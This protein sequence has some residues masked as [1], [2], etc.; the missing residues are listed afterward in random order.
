MRAERSWPSGFLLALVQRR[1][2]RLDLREHEDK[3]LV[4]LALVISALVGLVVVG[5]VAMTERMGRILLTAGPLQRLVSPVIGS[6]A[7][8]WLLYRFFPDARG[9]GIPQTRIALILQKGVIS[10]RTVVGKFICSAVSLGSGLALGREGPSVHIG[11]G[12]ASVAGRRLGLS[13]EKLRTLIPVGTAAAIAA[14]FNTPLAA[15]LF[16]LEEI[17]ADLHARLV[18]SVVLGAATSWIVLRLILGDEPL[19]HVPAY[20]LVHPLEFVI[21]GLL[22]IIGGLIS[23]GFVK[24]LLWQRAHF[25]RV[26]G[27]WKA[28]A[29]VAGGLTVGLLA[30]V[31]PGVL[32]VGYNLVS[33]ALN[34]HVEIRVMLILMV[35]KIVATSTSYG[36]GNCGGVFGP[37]LFIGA[38]MGGAI[39]QTAHSLFPD[40][41]GNAGAYA[42]VG[43]GAAFAGIVRTP[44]TSVIMIFEVTRDY[45][46]IVPLM[47]ANLLSYLLAERLQTLPLYEALSRQEGVR[48]PSAEH[49][50]EPMAVERAMTALAAGDTLTLHEVFVHPDDPLDAALQRMG[51]AN[52]ENIVVLNRTG[53]LP[54]GAL[55][56]QSAFAAYR[57]PAAKDN[58]TLTAAAQDWLPAIAAI[59][60]ASV[61]IVA[62]LVFWQRAHRS[63]TGASE[64]RTGQ[65]LLGQGRVE[66]AV[67]AFRSSLAHLPA[68]SNARTAL[69]FALLRSG[70][71]EEAGE[72]LAEAAK[73]QPQNGLLWAGV[74]NV[75]LALDQ[76]AEALQYFR[77]ALAGEWPDSETARLRTSQIT[78]SQLLAESGKR[79]EAVASLFSV[80]EQSGGDASTGKQAA[81][82]IKDIG[83]LE[84]SE[85]AYKALSAHFPADPAVWLALGDVR[86]AANK[87]RA[88]LEAYRN[89]ATVD[90]RNEAAARSVRRV[91][92]VMDI[93]P[94]RRGLGWEERSRRWDLLFERVLTT[95]TPCLG[96]GELTA[97]AA[98]IQRPERSLKTQHEKASA[99]QHIWATVDAACRTDAVLS[100]VIAN[101][102]E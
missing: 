96:S 64:Y 60:L 56:I 100:H 101:I 14:A 49:I 13:D 102:N 37:S 80:M 48:M 98:L 65:E 77:R 11:A 18:G 63:A 99:I 88:A 3:I 43:M 46:I 66:E 40:Y 9:S 31:H 68:D 86:F 33:E 26:P 52:V 71:F 15:V 75:K 78:F 54:V 38:M 36:S 73:A 30:L 29:P 21:Y 72:Y 4:M 20:Q 39:G 90:P 93:D 47:I 70:H 24:L 22:G 50:P 92:E 95:A 35:L 5:F 10:F 19:F 87:D 82:A 42:L 1:I 97:A 55:S 27:R 69:G 45:T 53:G 12:I 89:A 61:A 59:T 57:R 81:Q 51:E 84:Q 76:K 44:M 23:T 7:G 91:E 34:G 85:A 25:L 41:T 28:V 17:L 79:T 2:A 6:L 74:A 62:G 8:G 83:T 94:T 16:T 32:G 58:G 67:V